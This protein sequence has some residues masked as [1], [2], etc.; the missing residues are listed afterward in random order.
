MKQA[1][2]WKRLITVFFHIVKK[3]IYF[4]YFAYLFSIQIWCLVAEINYYINVA[5]W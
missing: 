5:A 1:E 3:N 2:T 4:T